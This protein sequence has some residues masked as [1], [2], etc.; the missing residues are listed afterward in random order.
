[1]GEARKKRELATR[2]AAERSSLEDAV[3]Q[4]SHALRRLA[5]A[6]SAHLGSDCYT[7]AE[8]GRELLA[9]LGFK[10]ETQVGYAAWRVGHGDSDII[11]HTKRA[12]MYTPAGVPPGQALPYH[13]WLSAG[14][15][16]VDFTTYQLRHKGALLD[17]ADGGRTQ[18]DWCPD[19]LL[20]SSIEVKPYKVVVQAPG[21]GLAHYEADA[22]LA[23]MMA[24]RYERDEADIAHARLI[25]RNPD[26]MVLGPNSV[27]FGG[28]A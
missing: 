2:L 1:M 11:A 14:D 5:Q 12:P 18:V 19:Y 23:T 16:L 21:P 15:W 24:A 22:D 7:H 6:A 28:E 10:F 4:V 26:V 8:I 9:D 3:K 17:A 25:L 13:A 20:L 27:G